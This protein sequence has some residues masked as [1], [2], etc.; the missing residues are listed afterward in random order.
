M[1]ISPF[2]TVLVQMIYRAVSNEPL[3]GYEHQIRWADVFLQ[4]RGEAPPIRRLHVDG[5]G[6]QVGPEQ[7]PI[8]PITGETAYSWLTWL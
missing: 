3:H 6:L 5:P 2:P 1:F 8:Q 4:H 7:V